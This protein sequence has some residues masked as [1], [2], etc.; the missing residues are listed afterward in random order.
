MRQGFIVTGTDTGIGKTLFSAALVQHLRG[1]YWKPV[2]SGINQLTDT[3]LV[4]RLA[5]DAVIIAEAYRLV[6]P[7]SPHQAAMIDGITI[8]PASLV[9][10][11]VDRLLVVEGAGGVL[12]PLTD[13]VP[14]AD[15]FRHWSLP[16]ILV[17]RTSLGTINHSLLSLEALRSRSIELHGIIFSGAANTESERIICHQGDVRHLGHLPLLDAINTETLSEAFNNHV[18]IGAFA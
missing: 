9:I 18:D 5:P 12:V 6:T 10:P 17:A 7:C 4:S 13:D 1:A 11:D 16:V 14:Y 3:E 2:Q 15:Q 8:D